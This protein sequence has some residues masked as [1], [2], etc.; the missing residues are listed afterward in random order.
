MARYFGIEDNAVTVIIDAIS[1]TDTTV[2]VNDVSVF[3]NAELPFVVTIADLNTDLNM[4]KVIVTTVVG[5]VLTIERGYQ[6]TPVAHSASSTICLRVIAQHVRDLLENSIYQIQSD[7]YME[8]T[9]N[10]T[11]QI[12][13]SDVWET[14]AKLVKLAKVTYAYPNTFTKLPIQAVRLIYYADGITTRRTETTDFT[15]VHGKLVNTI[16]TVDNTWA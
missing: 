14:S 6:T 13:Q 9:L 10:G 2:T 12:T 5:S 15:W 16:K 3:G 1:D 8:H 11:L 4:E 7:S